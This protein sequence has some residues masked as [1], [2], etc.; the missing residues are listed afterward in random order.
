MEVAKVMLWTART[1][2]EG[3]GGRTRSGAVELVCDYR[4]PVPAFLGG[5]AQANKG[6]VEYVGSLEVR[7]AVEKHPC[8]HQQRERCPDN[9]AYSIVPA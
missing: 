8:C 1:V 3:K 9:R 4:V 5:T 6:A 2:P 7:E